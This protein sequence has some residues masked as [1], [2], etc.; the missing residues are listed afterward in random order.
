MDQEIV[1]FFGPFGLRWY[2]LLFLGGILTG[3]HFFAKMLIAEGK[4]VELRETLLYYVVLGTVIGAR[5]GHCLFYDP[6]YYFSEPLRILK[7]WEGG[8]ASHGGFTGVIIAVYL[9]SRKNKEASFFWLVD[10]LAIWGILVGAF[11]RVGNFFN[12]EIIG[13]VTDV[14]WAV[15]FLKVDQLP[16]HPSQLYE[17]FGYGSICLSL[18]LLYRYWDRKPLEGRLLGLAFC[19]AYAFRFLVENLKENQVSY[20]DSMMFN[21]GQLLS[22]PFILLGIFL[23]IGWQT[24]VKALSWA[25]TSGAQASDTT[26]APVKKRKKKR[27]SN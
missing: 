23:V 17:A 16:R 10:R 26:D 20:E 6:S 19:I 14:P 2:S 18:Y 8:L 9:F 13:R 21:M 7:V 11:I 22:V 25:F 15:V 12:S 24:K 3:Y 27:K 1:H 5:L 4:P